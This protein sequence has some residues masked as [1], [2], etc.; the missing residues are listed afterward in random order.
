MYDRDDHALL[1]S[2]VASWSLFKRAEVGGYISNGAM[3]NVRDHI[4]NV[5]VVTL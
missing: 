4:T 3:L 2:S 5:L 1:T